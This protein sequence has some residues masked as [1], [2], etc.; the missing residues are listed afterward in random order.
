MSDKKPLREG[1]QPTGQRGYQPTPGC[2]TTP[3]PQDVTRPPCG[4]P[5]V[6][7]PPKTP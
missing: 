4:P 5:G 6:N 7:P 3:R 1:Y 2:P